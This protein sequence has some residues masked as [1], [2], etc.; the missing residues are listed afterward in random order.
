MTY[1]IDFLNEFMDGRE[2]IQ[3][4]EEANAWLES[5]QAYGP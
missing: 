3:T 2:R 5:C 1:D 4:V